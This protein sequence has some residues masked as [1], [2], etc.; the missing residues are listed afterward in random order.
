MRNGSGFSDTGGCLI[1]LLH[2][3]SHEPRPRATGGAPERSA[4]QRAV[5]R[6]Y[7]LRCGAEQSLAIGGVECEVLIADRGHDRRREFPV[8]EDRA[9]NSRVP[10]V[11]PKSS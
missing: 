2:R 1:F 5:Q 8:T 7:L 11:E 6:L 3:N 4:D 10:L 9:R